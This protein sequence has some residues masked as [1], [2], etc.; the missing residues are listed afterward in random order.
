MPRR[1]STCSP[2]RLQPWPLNVVGTIVPSPVRA[3][4]AGEFTVASQNLF[5][6]FDTTGDPSCDDDVATPA[7]FADRLNNLR[8]AFLCDD[9]RTARLADLLRAS[10]AVSPGR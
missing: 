7:L 1:A 4:A 2:A 3:R 5:R 10:P 8:F 6:L 9:E